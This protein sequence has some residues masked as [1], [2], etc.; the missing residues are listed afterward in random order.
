MKAAFVV[1]HVIFLARMELAN[2][3]VFIPENVF[4][5]AHHFP[6]W[7]SVRLVFKRHGNML[8]PFAV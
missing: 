3:L 1:V 8:P 4:Y 6:A 7:A 2:N 5:F